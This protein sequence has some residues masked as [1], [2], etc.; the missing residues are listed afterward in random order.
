M[1]ELLIFV[2]SS[3]KAANLKSSICYSLD[4]L[5]F[6]QRKL[7]DLS[8][9]PTLL[10]RSPQ[11]GL[12]VFSRWHRIPKS[13]LL[14]RTVTGSIFAIMLSEP[15][16]L[17]KEVSLKT[18]PFVALL[19]TWQVSKDPKMV[20]SASLHR[21]SLEIGAVFELRLEDGLN[22]VV[23]I[24]FRGSESLRVRSEVAELELWQV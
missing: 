3:S 5:E 12:N 2:Y 18:T 16:K 8:A 11:D 10:F 20:L 13:L 6:L 21:T 1:C 15:L 9:T 17:Q 7:P 4:Q 19:D 22:H 14:G 23:I 24:S